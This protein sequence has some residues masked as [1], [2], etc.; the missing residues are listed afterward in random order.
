[1]NMIRGGW[2]A[3][4]FASCVRGDLLPYPLEVSAEIEQ[5]G[6][7]RAE[8]ADVHAG[9]YDKRTFATGDQIRITKAGAA[10]ESALY[11]R[12][13]DGKW[14]LANGQSTLTTTGSDGFT[15]S[16]PEA[17]TQILADQASATGFWQSN[18]LTATATMN[19]NKASFIF[20]P[21]AAKVTIVVG[22]TSAAT[23]SAI[24]LTG[25]GIC[26][27]SG[28]ETIQPFCVSGTGSAL[29]HTYVAIVHPQDGQKLTVT[30]K[31]T[32]GDTEETLSYTDAAPYTMQ[33]GYNYQYTFTSDAKLILTGVSVD[34]FTETS[35]QNV[36]NAT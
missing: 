11:A 6:I 2:I 32:V 5:P 30:S 10:G 33:A 26:T 36:G 22:Y 20:A 14:Q 23:P 24:T 3:L 18:R 25:T 34:R 12:T 8:D 19:G 1:M 9:D 16:Y 7:T 4:V 35:E 27:G 15:A 13:S 21:V 28:A 17:F 29:S 31:R